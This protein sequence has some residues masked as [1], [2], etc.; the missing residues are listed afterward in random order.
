MARWDIG[1]T[2]EL[3]AAKHGPQQIELMRNCLRSVYERQRHARFHFQEARNIMKR[4]I[5]DRLSEES[6]FQITW[7]ADEEDQFE[8]DKC[9]MQVE[10]HVIACAQAIHSLADNLA[11]VAYFSLG[12]NLSPHSL[13]ERDVALDSVVKVLSTKFPAGVD[14]AAALGALSSEASFQL[15][16]AF[17]NTTKHRGYPETRINIDPTTQHA[18]YML[19][20]GAFD[21]RSQAHPA[22]EIEQVLMPSYA[23]ASK[24]VVTCGNAINAAL[25]A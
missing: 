4:H 16:N 14:V 12:V 3:V 10:A 5:D 7:P 20:F 6:I 9:F 8:F 1:K 17:V 23:A 2:R 21:Y 15:V 11:H 18:P 24:A 13:R 25:S 19:E 22:R